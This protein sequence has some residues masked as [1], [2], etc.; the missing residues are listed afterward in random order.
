M[1]EKPYS[2]LGFSHLFYFIKIGKF[3]VQNTR[4]SLNTI[5]TNSEIDYNVESTVRCSM[6]QSHGYCTRIILCDL[7]RVGVFTLCPF[8]PIR[9]LQGLV[10]K[11]VVEVV[12]ARPRDMNH[13]LGGT[14]LRVLTEVA[15]AA[16][17][18]HCQC[19][20]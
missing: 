16:H 2:F 6:S 17:T 15:V 4:Y 5:C 13:S 9:S 20:T 11:G 14:H 1:L 12:A 10:F 19:S 7:L 18:V 8:I 3:S